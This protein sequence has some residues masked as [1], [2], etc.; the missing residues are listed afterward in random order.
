MRAP[1]TPFVPLA[2][3]MLALAL[4]PGSAAAQRVEVGNAAAVV[5]DVRMSNAQ[6]TR[7]REVERKQQIGRA[8][9]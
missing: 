3:G 1:A 5:G 9:V 7:P 2:A 8:H 6:I 4:L